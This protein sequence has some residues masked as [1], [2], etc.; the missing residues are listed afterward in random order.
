MNI[1]IFNILLIKKNN[2]IILYIRNDSNIIEAPVDR[3]DMFMLIFTFFI[4][5]IVEK[6]LEFINDD[7]KLFQLL[8]NDIINSN[9]NQLNRIF[10]R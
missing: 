2:K 6:N 8:S 10:C 7:I 9:I 4:R 1:K 3:Y 5:N